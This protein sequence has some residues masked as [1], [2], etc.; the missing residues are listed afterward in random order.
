[1]AHI[2]GTFSNPSAGRL[3]VTLT[4]SF[5]QTTNRD[6]GFPSG[7][8]NYLLGGSVN[9][10]QMSPLDRNAP[11]SYMEL[12][13]PGGNASWVVATSTID[14]TGS[15]VSFYGFTNIRMILQLIKK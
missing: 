6:V 10:N 9:G 7:S 14:T 3:R 4:G 13:Y 5:F 8:S 11:V 2:S 15:G 1:M 12:D